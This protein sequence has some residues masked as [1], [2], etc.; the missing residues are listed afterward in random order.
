[1]IMTNKIMMIVGQEINIMSH[2]MKES[3]IK[4]DTITI[5]VVIIQKGPEIEDIDIMTHHR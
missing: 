3:I 5:V 2:H 4:M 1:M